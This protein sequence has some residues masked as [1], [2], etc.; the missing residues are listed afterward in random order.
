V[1]VGEQRVRLKQVGQWK[2]GGKA[3]LGVDHDEP[4][5][6]LHSGPVEQVLDGD[7]LEGISETTPTSHTMDVTLDRLS[8]QLSEFLPGYLHGLF[9]QTKE[10]KLPPLKVDF[11]YIT[12]VEDWPLL[13]DDLPGR[14]AR[15]V[16]RSP[17]A[18]VPMK[19]IEHEWPL[20]PDAAPVCFNR[21]DTTIAHETR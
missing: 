6:R 12:V 5:F 20:L 18:S 11:W 3:L 7:A 2:V 19:E 14:N 10:P 4:G 8:G 17:V 21:Y 9:D 1:G 15:R 16:Y 13:G